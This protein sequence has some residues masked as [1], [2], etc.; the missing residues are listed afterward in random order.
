[1]PIKIADLKAAAAIS[2]SASPKKLPFK[3]AIAHTN[4]KVAWARHSYYDL[5]ADVHE[6][7]FMVAGLA[8][9]D[10]LA[11]IQKAVNKA[12]AEGQTLRNFQKD[13]EKIVADRWDPNGGVAW[14]A[15]VIWETNMRTSYAAGRYK[16]MKGMAEYNPYWM[17]CHGDSMKPRP[18]H[19]ELDRVVL[20]HDDPWWDKNYPPNDWGCQCYVRCLTEGEV[21]RGGYKVVSGSSL[22][23]AATD[24]RWQHA[25]G[26]ETALDLG[27][28]EPQAAPEPVKARMPEQVQP[29]ASRPASAQPGGIPPSGEGG[30]PPEIVPSDLPPT[31]KPAKPAPTKEEAEDQKLADDF[32]ASMKPVLEALPSGFVA[33]LNRVLKASG[34]KFPGSIGL[35][36]LPVGKWAACRASKLGKKGIPDPKDY[37]GITFDKEFVRK[38]LENKMMD[39][40]DGA[41]GIFVD[42]ATLLEIEIPS[43]EKQATI[44]V[45]ELAHY[46]HWKHTPK[47]DKLVYKVMCKLVPG[48]RAR[49]RVLLPINETVKPWKRRP[50]QMT[51]EEWRKE[52]EKMAKARPH[53]K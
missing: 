29:S 37:I 12:I 17:Y 43:W 19:L 38:C 51:L 41:Y 50:N 42:P 33:K 4:Q 36:D 34:Q 3:E 39:S 16:Q 5:P 24:P 7:A 8:K 49:T 18:E 40:Y 15:R 32:N 23:D 21:R 47:H 10:V 11:D 44:A 6:R 13:F 52:W 14:R 9:E 20:R 25:H 22:P 26:K 46:I 35:D 1:M 53:A 2:V 28:A 27:P 48:Y 31:P 30:M 45:H